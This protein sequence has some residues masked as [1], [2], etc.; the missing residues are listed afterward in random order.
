MQ[1]CQINATKRRIKVNNTMLDY[2]ISMIAPHKCRGCGTTGDLLCA[3]CIDVILD[4]EST[5]FCCGK[6]TF[7]SWLCDLCQQKCAYDNAWATG[8]YE[9]P[10]KSALNDFKFKRARAAYKVFADMLDAKLPV[11][12]PEIVITNVPT[13]SRR[14]RQ[15]GYDQTELVARRL[16][17]MRHLPYRHLLIRVNQSQQVGANKKTRKQ[18]AET[19][20]EGCNATPKTVLIIDDVCTTGATLAAVAAKL[21]RNGAETVLVATLAYEPLRGKIS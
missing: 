19:T 11:M 2:L 12:P 9:G 6:P 7:Q 13:A 1:N 17:K 21:R 5:C 10:L 4:T 8:L 3:S 15:R 20:Y 18:Q 16:A 14:I